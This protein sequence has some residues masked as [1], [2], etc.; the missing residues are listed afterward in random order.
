M[1]DES[2]MG[3]DGLLVTTQP[4]ME[5][6]SIVSREKIRDGVIDLCSNGQTRALHVAAGKALHS[7]SRVR[8]F[9]VTKAEYESWTMRLDHPSRYVRFNASNVPPARL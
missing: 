3:V 5:K 9:P 1:A 8:Y 4:E 2:L 6:L 7:R